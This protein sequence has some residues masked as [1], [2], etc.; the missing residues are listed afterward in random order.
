MPRDDVAELVRRGALARRGGAPDTVDALRVREIGATS[1]CGCVEHRILVSWRPRPGGVAVRRYQ[2]F[3]RETDDEDWEHVGF[4]VATN[5]LLCCPLRLLTRYVVAV[6]AESPEGATLPIE[7]CAQTVFTLYGQEAPPA[8]PTAVEV[9]R[10]DEGH[11]VAWDPVEYAAPVRYEVRVGGTNWEGAVPVGITDDPFLELRDL[12][13]AS[14][15]V[16]SESVTLL[17]APITAT[18]LRGSV[19]SVA[20]DLLDVAPTSRVYGT[21]S[22]GPSWGGTATGCAASGGRLVVSAGQ[23]SATYEHTAKDFGIIAERLIVGF[24]DGAVENEGLTWG[25]AFFRW[26]SPLAN[27]T[28]D[29]GAEEWFP[30]AG[31][32][33][34]RSPRWRELDFTW[35]SAAWLTWDSFDPIRDPNNPADLRW[36]DAEITWD[37]AFAASWTWDGPVSSVGTGY[38]IEIATS[39]DNVAWTAWSVYVPQARTFRYLKWRLRIT[40]PVP[41]LAVSFGHV[42]FVG[43]ARMS[44]LF[45][46]ERWRV[47]QDVVTGELV[48]AK[49]DGTT[50][51]AVLRIDDDALSVAAGVKIGLDGETPVARDAGWGASGYSATRTITGASPLTDVA[52]ALCT[53]VDYFKSRGDLDS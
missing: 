21:S 24:V 7:A 32:T 15:A 1:D 2:I 49:W 38:V 31:I 30:P 3:L 13:P 9:T 40:Q 51:T 4:S 45:V 47:R 17:V 12:F 35:D 39:N 26:D 36:G 43:M 8:A 25:T 10:V 16:P 46:G 50:E 23:T 48:V 41:A 22:A 37:S 18:G 20:S 5:K 27:R 28:W 19:A 44:T 34:P 6:A 42:S 53:L 33:W 11:V 14:Q 52:A 29:G